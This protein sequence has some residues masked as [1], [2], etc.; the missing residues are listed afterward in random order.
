MAHMT[1]CTFLSIIKIFASIF[2]IFYF[3]L[4]C[5]IL[6]YS[7]N[8]DFG[9]VEDENFDCREVVGMKVNP[10][11]DEWDVSD[12]PLGMI[13]RADRLTALEYVTGLTR[14]QPAGEEVETK[15]IDDPEENRDIFGISRY[16]HGEGI[17]IQINSSWLDQKVESRLSQLD[18]DHANM[19]LASGKLLPS[20]KEQ[21]PAVGKKNGQNALTVL[22]TF[23]HLIIKELCGMSN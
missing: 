5:G 22:H 19:R 20:F 9:Q 16:N 21:M 11:N 17:Y 13:S 8:D 1:Q 18:D 3:F 4:K 2:G 7:E 15:F 10:Q 14:I 6:R 23:S 12:W